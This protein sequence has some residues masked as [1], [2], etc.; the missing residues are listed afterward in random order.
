MAMLFHAGNFCLV[1]GVVEITV[2]SKE[3]L[4][5]LLDCIDRKTV[6]GKKDYAILMLAI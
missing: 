3:D 4:N 2:Y 1:V 5:K 6:T